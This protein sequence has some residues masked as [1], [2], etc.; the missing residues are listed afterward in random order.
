MFLFLSSAL[1]NDTLSDILSQPFQARQLLSL[2][3][4]P[5]RLLTTTIIDGQKL[6]PLNSG[7]PL[8]A[9]LHKKVSS[10]FSEKCFICIRIIDI[11]N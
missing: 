5:G 7:L 9:K 8:R 1:P 2:H 6:S 4:I 10:T 3:I 11:E